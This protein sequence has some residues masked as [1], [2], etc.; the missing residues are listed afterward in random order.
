MRQKETIGCIN[1]GRKGK[2]IFKYKNFN[3]YKCKKCKL[4]STL[5]YPTDKQI[6]KHYSDGFKKGN[7]KFLRDFSDQYKKVYKQL[8]DIL[9]NSFDDKS[10]HS[11]KILDVG[12]FTGEF[13]EILSN[14]GA[15]VYGLEIQ[16]E[17][18]KIANKKLSGRVKEVDLN[19]YKIEGSKFDAISLLGIIEHVKNP[20][21]L[22]IQSH[23]I[24]KKNGIL[25][26]QTPNSSSF[27]AKILGK[28]WPPYSP[29]EHI[30]LY[31]H[32]SI[33]MV[34]SESGFTNVK[35]K[36]HWKKLPLGYIYNMFN[37]FGPEFHKL[38]KPFKKHIK[39]SKITVPVYIGELII[40][41]RKK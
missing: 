30:H 28:Y 27:F 15:D 12:C 19:N 21:R 40:T 2:L 38:L 4:V 25:I 31:G 5:P 29:V 13:L 24:L 10:L 34:L 39:M 22:I 9:E 7:Y 35:F 37:I 36:N 16:P 26:I 14:R 41:A 23:S 32:T 11:K 18:V 1:C 6:L 33:K 17:A 20:N 8:A 3:Y